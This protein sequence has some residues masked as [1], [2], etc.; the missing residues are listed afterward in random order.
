MLRLLCFSAALVVAIGCTHTAAEG[1]L[2]EP[3]IYDLMPVE[4]K[5]WS[6]YAGMTVRMTGSAEE[7]KRSAAVDV[8]EIGPVY[9]NNL[10]GWPAGLAGKVVTVT[11]ILIYHPM[12]EPPE[13][14]GAY[15]RGP[16]Y[17]LAS[18]T[19]SLAK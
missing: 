9:V 11:G 6:D 4:K 16:Y 5:L 1:R 12:R 13:N 7:C 8:S 10:N 19:W 14:G 18:A 17:S 15:I 2:G 3:S